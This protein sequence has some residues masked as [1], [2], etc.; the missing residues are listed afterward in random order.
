MKG[1]GDSLQLTDSSLAANAFEATLA[2]LLPVWFSKVHPFWLRALSPN[3]PSFW[4]SSECTPR[5]FP[6]ADPV[7]EPLFDSVSNTSGSLIQAQ[8]DSFIT[9]AFLRRPRPSRIRYVGRHDVA[10]NWRSRESHRFIN[11]RYKPVPWVQGKVAGFRYIPDHYPHV[12]PENNEM[13]SYTPNERF[14]KEDRKL[15]VRPGKYLRKHFPKMSDKAIEQAAAIWKSEF[16]LELKVATTRKK[17]RWVYQKGPNSCMSGDFLVR[18]GSKSYHPAEVYA[19]GDLGVAYAIKESNPDYPI[20]RC[21]CLPNEKLFSGSMYGDYESLTAL[22]LDAGWGKAR[23]DA[24]V[25]KKLLKITSGGDI[26]MPYI[27]VNEEVTEFDDHF[28]LGSMRGGIQIYEPSNTNG[29]LAGGQ[30]CSYCERNFQDDDYFT[31]HIDYA[32]VCP[33]CWCDSF[34]SCCHCGWATLLEELNL[35]EE[36]GMW[37]CDECVKVCSDCSEPI[38][39]ASDTGRCEPCQEE[40]DIEEQENECKN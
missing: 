26:L 24:W 3:A 8:L 37:Y 33:D 7:S 29:L 12:N 13:L 15:T 21:L 19:A 31:D 11:N 35:V 1:C 34:G 6:A 14:G 16:S 10:E 9:G 38:P 18:I 27:D 36:N 5:W 28:K 17:I 32:A 23:M 4:T 25:G 39:Y 22:L 20:A 40:F 2:R 30:L